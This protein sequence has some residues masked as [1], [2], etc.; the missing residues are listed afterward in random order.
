ML[1]S[2][3]LLT[4]KSAC[5][6]LINLIRLWISLYRI[7]CFGACPKCC[8]ETANKLTTWTSMETLWW[9][10]SLETFLPEC[11]Q[12]FDGSG[13]NCGGVWKSEDFTSQVRKT[14]TLYFQII[15]VTHLGW[16]V[17][18]TLPGLQF[19]SL[20]HLLHLSQRY[21]NELGLWMDLGIRRKH[22]LYTFNNW[23]HLNPSLNY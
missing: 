13:L 18:I 1:S 7:A 22:L 16:G 9:V 12:H 20:Y 17:Y 8:F 4:V 23:L 3:R 21:L 15:K 10:L 6:S 2:H 19:A 14:L 5:S 11:Q